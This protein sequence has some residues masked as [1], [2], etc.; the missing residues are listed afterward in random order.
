MALPSAVDLI[1]WKKYFNSYTLQGRRNVRIR[2]QTRGGLDLELATKK[3][4]AAHT[5]SLN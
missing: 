5:N 1:G 4:R 3:T 2:T